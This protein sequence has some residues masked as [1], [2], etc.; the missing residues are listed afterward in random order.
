MS[1]QNYSLGGGLSKEQ[2]DILHERAL[3]LCETE[4]ITI[5]HKGIL[6]ILSQ[7]DGVKIEKDIAKFSPEVIMEAL[8][9]AVYDEPDYAAERWVLEAGAHQT[10][11][12][13]I[14]ACKF[15]PANTRDLIDLTKLGD[16]LD[17]SGSAPVVP[18]DVPDHLKHILM[19]KVS[20]EYSRFR[21]ND[22]YEHM[23]KPTYECAQYVYDMAQAAGK[24][25]TF[26]VWMISPKSFDAKGLEVAYRLRDKNI[27]M[28]I[29]TMPI[30]GISSPITILSSVLQSMYEHFCGLAMLHLINPNANNYISPDDAF[31]ADAFDMKWCTFVYGSP[32]Y[33]RHTLHQI[34][35]CN[36]YGIPI[37][38]K[39]MLTSAK[40]PDAHMATEI[41]THTL[42]A[43]LGGARVFRNAGLL[44]TGEIYSAEQLVICCE[45]AEYV[46]NLIKPEEFSAERLM[47]DEIRAVKP[48]QLH[49]S[50]ECTVD[51]YL[52]EYWYPELFTHSN[53]DQWVSRENGRSI[54]E[55]ARERAKKLTAQHEYT[56][57][58]DVI[59]ELNKLYNMAE[60]DE[61]LEASFKS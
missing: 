16:A 49:I 22:I 5:P 24:R 27:P 17:T 40:E 50:R 42:I 1:I 34:A 23:D 56:A 60:H 54:R 7:H 45:I 31:E 14:D 11:V 53:Y 26:G 6:D 35:L 61:Q 2:L 58:E 48:G 13:D 33:T 52:S 8:D 4:G 19:H 51:N 43:A 9:A 25:F 55:A 28:W 46:Q 44:S 21:C 37:N 36:Y 10:M 20:F 59:K 29:S 38:A 57:D 3:D 15:R 41:A 47:E 32:E 30:A 18:L 39:S 12:F